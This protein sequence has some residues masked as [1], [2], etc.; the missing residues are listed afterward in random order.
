MREDAQC[1]QRRACGLSCVH[2]HV[3][4]ITIITIHTPPYTCTESTFPPPHK[5][6]KHGNVSCPTPPQTHLVHEITPHKGCY[7]THHHWKTC[8]GGVCA[9]CASVNM[10]CCSW[11]E[12][13]SAKAMQPA[14][15]SSSEGKHIALVLRCGIDDDHDH[16]HIVVLI[17]TTTSLYRAT[18]IIKQIYTHIAHL[19]CC[20]FLG[21][22]AINP[23]REAEWQ[24]IVCSRKIL[25]SICRIAP[26]VSLYWITQWGGAGANVRN[27]QG[28]Q[29]GVHVLC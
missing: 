14:S 21:C 20:V 17:T 8:P 10:W 27:K 22:D 29:H 26:Q 16:M 24:N 28:L 19:G 9:L 12:K 4:I 15:V 25:Y 2:D 5:E 23:P 18:N 3:N 11:W 1:A 13:T 7:Q 6:L